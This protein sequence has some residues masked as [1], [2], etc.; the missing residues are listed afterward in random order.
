MRAAVSSAG[1]VALTGLLSAAVVCVAV[2]AAPGHEGHDLGITVRVPLVLLSEGQRGKEVYDGK[3]LSCHGKYTEGT[4]AGPSLVPYD[5]A[6]HPDGDFARAM[7]DGVRQHHWNFGDMP[8]I[9]GL[10]E[11]EVADIISYVRELQAFNAEP[12]DLKRGHIE[13]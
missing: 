1:R 10:T 3:C 7:R 11:Q 13:K 4:H 2:K 5:R 12:Q 6:H 8:P 9:E